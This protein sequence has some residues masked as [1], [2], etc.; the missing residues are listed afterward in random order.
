[1]SYLKLCQLV[2]QGNPDENGH[3]QTVFYQEDCEGNVLVNNASY[4]LVLQCE[5]ID[6]VSLDEYQ[7]RGKTISFTA[8][9]V[10]L[11]TKPKPP[12][13]I[14]QAVIDQLILTYPEIIK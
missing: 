3:A 14:R 7:K 6:W 8:G 4:P 1:M 10:T 9:E 5:I 13:T 11:S 12:K 2:N